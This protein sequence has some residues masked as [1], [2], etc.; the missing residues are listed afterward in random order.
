MFGQPGAGPC[1]AQMPF[2]KEVEEHYKGNDHVVFVGISLDAEKDKQKWLNMIKEKQLEGI[3]LL[4]DVGKSF[5]RKYKAVAIPRFFLIDKQGKWSEVRCP[6][7]ES[8]E[9]LK[10]YIDRELNRSI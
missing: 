2:L 8:S 4:D 3:Q 6:L 10:K 5:G 9:K 1:K 7:P